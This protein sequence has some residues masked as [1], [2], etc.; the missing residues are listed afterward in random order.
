MSP[1]LFSRELF[2]QIPLIGIIRDVSFDDV[3]EI[4]PI[5]QQA[6][7]TS[8]EITMNTACVEQIIP[9]ARDNF[10]G[11]N[12]GAGTVCTTDDLDKALDLGAQFIVT[13][14]IVKKVIKSCKKQGIP[15]FPGAYTPSE[16]YTAWSLGA[17]M[18]KIYP[19]T[20]LGPSYIKDLKAP[21]KHIPL[22][23]TGGVNLDNISAFREAGA[24][25]FGVGSQLFNKMLIKE[26]DW[27]GLKKHFKAFADQLLLSKK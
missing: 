9:Y 6:G 1:T 26:R 10:P 25:G 8:I 14:V 18:V 20:A 16:I 22:M 19:A 5:Y 17:T 21:L 4:L 24:D 27:Q 13:P 11:L 2:D 23:P 12:V 7:L 3:R 15:I